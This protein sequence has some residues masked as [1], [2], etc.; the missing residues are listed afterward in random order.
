M[1]TR[2]LCL[3]TEFISYSHELLE[4]AV[5]DADSRREVLHE[6]YRPRRARRWSSAIHGITPERVARCPHFDRRLPDLQRLF[7][8]PTHIVGFAVDNDISELRAQGVERLERKT[9]VDVRDFYWLCRGA[10]K[11]YTLFN[12]PGLGQCAA[13]LGITLSPDEEHT[14][15]GDAAVT[16]RLFHALADEFRAAGGATPEAPLDELWDAASRLIEEER[17]EHFRRSAMG[18][19]TLYKQNRIYTLKATATPPDAD[20][21]PENPDKPRAVATISVADRYRAEHELNL[22]FKARATTPGA[23]SYRLLP[24]H[25]SLFKRYSNTYDPEKAAAFKA[26][27][28]PKRSR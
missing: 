18:F 21:I 5:Y 27:V 25:I 1:S 17:R 12:T 22:R 2:L 14:A 20:V 10:E 4:L 26:L 19:I 8:S 6:F 23:H 9:L 3:D 15:S 28:R 16:M 11:G 7:D 13:E 24:Y